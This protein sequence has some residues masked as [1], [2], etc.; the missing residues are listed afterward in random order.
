MLSSDDKL[1]LLPHIDAGRALF[2]SYARFNCAIDN[3]Q[4]LLFRHRCM[5]SPKTYVE[6]N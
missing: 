6:C 1:Q 5:T 4:F 2:Y 3:K